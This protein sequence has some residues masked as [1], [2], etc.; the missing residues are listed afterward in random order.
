M[1]IQFSCFDQKELARRETLFH[2]ANGYLGLRG[3]FEEGVPTSARFIRGTYI[4]GFYDTAPIHYEERLYGFARTQ[5]SIVNIIDAQGIDILLD[6]E[7]FTCFEGQLDSFHQQLDMNTGVYTR[8][9]DWTSPKGQKTR[10]VFSRLA[11][12]VL[13]QLAVIR[14]AI[15][16]LNWSGEARLTSTQH[17]DVVQDFDLNDPRKAS[18]GRKMID[19]TSASINDGIL[20]MNAR[21][22]QSGLTLTSAVSHAASAGFTASYLQEGKV[23]SAIF[24]AAAKEGQTVAL[25][26]YCVFADSRR[27]DKPEETAKEL[28][29]TAVK[30]NFETW[31][32]K[33]Q[34]YLNDF[35]LQSGAGVTGDE[36]LNA[37]LNWSMFTLLAAAGK[38]GIGNIAS[39]GLSGEGYEGHYFWDTEIYMF[40]FFV[41]TQP[42]LAKKLL[43]SRAS[44]LPEAFEHAR[45][46]GHE[47]GAL[48]AWRT[49][50]GSE[51]S[52]YFPSG[53]AQYHI[54]G[55]VAHAF[56]TYY[57][58]TG[59]LQ[60]MA[61]T[62][63]C[64]L[65]ETARLWMDA[66]HWY[67]GQFRIDSVTGPDEYSCVVN[68]NYYTN[69][70]AQ[71]HLKNLVKICDDLKQAGLLD[72]VIAQTGLDQGEVD[73]FQKAAEGMYLPYDE[74]LGISAQDDAF[75]KK[76][77]LD[78]AL[79][80]EDKHPLLMHFHP[81]FLY[82]HQVCKQADTVLSHFLFEEGEDEEV[83]RRSYDYYERITTHDSSLSEC[84][85]AMMA[86]RTG[87][88]DKAYHYYRASA[89][90]DL[91]DTH[92]N[93]ADGIHAANMGGC[94]MGIVFGFGGLRLHK[95]GL[96][97]R[98]CLPKEMA[99]YE[100]NL[101]WR[102]SHIK[103]AV[104]AKGLTLTLLSGPAIDLTV[105]NQRHN[106]K[107]T[108]NLPL[109]G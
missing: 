77:S 105:C 55:A 34:T 38:D 61:R 29:T 22:T 93:T 73:D 68:N 64:V 27:F 71:F 66:G 79:I 5:Q 24:T 1:N 35:W 18:V 40:P 15:T 12:F 52:A 78:L 82:R 37:S 67:E 81:L 91:E 14:V 83:I 62:G 17:G 39:K 80:P 86:A 9:V 74:R 95:D 13:P 59:D 25:T 98:P 101:R 43:D 4:N 103:A 75:L 2:V 104:D 65:V 30:E 8:T 100:F 16:P 23:N 108:L 41:L 97:L 47:Q 48:Y 19:I 33:Q 76:Q 94:W 11:S 44:M 26:K 63:A 42:K 96:V 102:G 28:L 72:E 10:L 50:T 32:G 69:R 7:A 84:V 57:H 36:G 6:G 21:T 45:E 109:I 20:L 107:K 56:I 85:F 92:K 31:Q 3:N 49:I 89:V 54:N 46:M 51:C 60:Y 87:Q 70:G 53:S 99:G 58:A 106:L 88:V 90:L